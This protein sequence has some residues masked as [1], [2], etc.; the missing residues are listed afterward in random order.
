MC[1]AVVPVGAERMTEEHYAHA[2]CSRTT[3]LNSSACR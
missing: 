3:G 1:V 2:A